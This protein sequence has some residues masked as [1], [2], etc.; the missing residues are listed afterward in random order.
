MVA[1][2]Q[3]AAARQIAPNVTALEQRQTAATAKLAALEAQLQEQTKR[4]DAIEAD[5][6]KLR[7]A[8][9]QAQ[10]ARAAA[11]KKA[12]P[13]TRQ[14]LDERFRTARALVRGGDPAQALRELLWCWDEGLKQGTS[15]TIPARRSGLTD[16]LREL[17]E[18]YPPAREEMEKRRAALHARILAS[19]GGGDSISEY[20][21]ILETLNEKKALLGLFDEIPA[22]DRRRTTLAI[23]AREPLIE[24]RRYA[25]AMEGHSFARMSAS[26]ETQAGMNALRASRDGVP[27]FFVQTTVKNIE[28]L[29]GSGDLVHARELAT[30][31]LAVDNS[32]ATRALIQQRAERAGQ[33]ELLK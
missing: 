13:L 15:A 29:A 14:A 27:S 12:E 6:A 31:L 9:V 1:W 32:P 24:A 21:S 30:R 17:A 22:G 20:A 25:E 4:A 33:P 26:F 8:L 11:P 19:A 3:R 7:A 16:G 18:R 5:N 10:A 23:Y 2:R 28:L